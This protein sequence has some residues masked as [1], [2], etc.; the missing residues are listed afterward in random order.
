VALRRAVREVRRL[1]PAPHA[2]GPITAPPG[3]IAVVDGLQR[4]GRRRREGGS[5]EHESDQ[6]QS[7]ERRSIG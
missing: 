4:R 3:A 5:G 7:P 2:G 1:A 6:T